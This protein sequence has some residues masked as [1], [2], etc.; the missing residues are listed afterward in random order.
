MRVQTAEKQNLRHA[1][2]S[3]GAGN[4][5]GDGTRERAAGADSPPNPDRFMIE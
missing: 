2:E 3:S 4:P 5:S 1:T